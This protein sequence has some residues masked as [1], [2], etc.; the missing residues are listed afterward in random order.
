[1]IVLERE[2]LIKISKKWNLSLS[3]SLPWLGLADKQQ[4][5]NGGQVYKVPL[6]VCLFPHYQ[7]V[8]ARPQGSS[9]Y[10]WGP[11]APSMLPVALNESLLY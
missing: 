9:R 6:A 11:A 7:E 8:R 2:L 10:L 4:R 5:S 1:M 3:L